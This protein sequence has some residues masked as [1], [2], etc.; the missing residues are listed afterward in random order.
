MRRL[1][2]RICGTGSC[3]MSLPSKTMLP[4]SMSMSRMSARPRVVLPEPELADDADGFAPFDPEVDAMQDFDAAHTFAVEAPFS[5]VGDL[6]A[7]RDQEI[8][9][10]V[11]A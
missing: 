7:A 5:P 1:K 3:V 6:D 9:S 2:G 4:A 8:L 10:H 11:A